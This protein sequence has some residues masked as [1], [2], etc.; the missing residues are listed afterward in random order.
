[1]YLSITVCSEVTDDGPSD[2]SSD[3]LGAGIIALI[4]VGS[5]VAILYLYCMASLCVS[6]CRSR[7]ADN[8]ARPVGLYELQ[9]AYDEDE[10]IEEIYNVLNIFD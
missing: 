7:R 9:D 4:V 10:D 8:Q 6:Y 1:M 5:V 2:S 3:S